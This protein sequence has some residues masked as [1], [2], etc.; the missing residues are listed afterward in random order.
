VV[1]VLAAA[2][3][4]MGISQRE[5][6]RRLDLHSM[7]VMKIELGRRDLTIGEFI[8]MARALGEDPGELLA[9]AQTK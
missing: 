6:S 1:T 4:R 8:A 2:R 9:R 7:T 3:E 5:L